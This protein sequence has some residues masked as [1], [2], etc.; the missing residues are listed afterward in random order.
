MKRT[1][2]LLAASLFVAFTSAVLAQTGWLTHAVSS[3]SESASDPEYRWR[4]SQPHH[5]RAYL[6][7]Q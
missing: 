4:F 2:M 3:R 5:W 7:Q 6:L 1:A